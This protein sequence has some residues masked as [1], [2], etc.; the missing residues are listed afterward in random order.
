M[1]LHPSPIQE[2]REQWA[3]DGDS[4][5][6][7]LDVK[8]HIDS[9]LSVIRKTLKAQTKRSEAA[10]R[11]SRD[12]NSAEEIGTAATNRRKEEGYHGLSD[13]D[14]A[15]PADERRKQIAEDL[16]TVGLTQAEADSHAGGMFSDG[17]KCDVH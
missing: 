14:E 12:A 15:L 10:T 1:R 2:L 6:I 7:L 9:N 11:H 17:R 8:Q 13:S 16:V 4:R 5:L 3:E